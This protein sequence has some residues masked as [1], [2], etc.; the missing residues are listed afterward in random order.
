M[1]LPRLELRDN[2]IDYLDGDEEVNA[3]TF[4]EKL[5]TAVAGNPAFAYLDLADNQIG[6]EGVGVWAVL[7]HVRGQVPSRQT[8][9]LR[10]SAK[11]RRRH[12][13][14]A[15]IAAVFAVHTLQ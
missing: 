12:H 2:H 5:A 11:G 14:L 6:N 3:V 1:P 13:R 4:V 7:P 8:P 15:E 10:Q 9:H